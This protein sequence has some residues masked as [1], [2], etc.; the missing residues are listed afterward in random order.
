MRFPEISETRALDNCTQCDVKQESCICTES[1]GKLVISKFFTCDCKLKF[2]Q[3]YFI[4]K[5]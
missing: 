5:H 1:I 3:L 2:V 4:I